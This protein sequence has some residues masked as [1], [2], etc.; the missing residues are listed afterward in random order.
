MVWTAY[1]SA[2]RLY[3]ITLLVRNLYRCLTREV[4][5]RNLGAEAGP[6]VG[7]RKSQ[8]LAK[9]MKNQC[10]SSAFRRR[11]CVDDEQC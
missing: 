4:K 9:L 2:T 5:A 1:R 3:F 10:E 6:Q 7:T 8:S 11:H